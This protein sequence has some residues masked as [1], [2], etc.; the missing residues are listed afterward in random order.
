MPEVVVEPMLAC[1]L[2]G[3][4]GRKQDGT[5]EGAGHPSHTVDSYAAAQRAACHEDW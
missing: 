2:E 1:A 4:H 3:Q 5:F